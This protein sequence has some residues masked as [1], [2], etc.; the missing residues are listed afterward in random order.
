MSRNK[1]KEF[2]R[3]W[4]NFDLSIG[5]ICKSIREAGIACYPVVDELINELQDEEKVHLDETPWYQKG[6]FCWFK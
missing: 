3:T 2:L 4:M 1:I 5:L 6:L